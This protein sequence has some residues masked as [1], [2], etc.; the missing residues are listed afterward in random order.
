MQAKDDN[1]VLTALRL[2]KT[3]HDNPESNEPGYLVHLDP[4]AYEQVRQ[5]LGGDSWFDE[6][7]RGSLPKYE[8]NLHIALESLQGFPKRW[9]EVE[10]TT[11]QEK[12]AA[13]SAN[14]LQCKDLIR[15]AIKKAQNVA[16]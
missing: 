3:L 7:A 11:L 2:V 8:L 12:L 5:A 4:K 9:P 14:I 6:E 10:D 13:L 15:K 1:K 16:R